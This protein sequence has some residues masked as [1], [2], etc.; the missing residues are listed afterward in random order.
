MPVYLTQFAYTAE[1]WSALVKHPED[2]SRVLGQLLEEVGGKLVCFYYAF[3]DYD[4][5]FI[6][7]AA[8][9]PASARRSRR[10]RWSPACASGW[11][12]RS[13]RCARTRYPPRAAR[14]RCCATTTRWTATPLTR[15][16]GVI[17]WPIRT[18]WRRSSRRRRAS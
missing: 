5:V 14:R 2:R 8:E 6:F 16:R 7:E 1:A 17:S 3:S 4:G 13:I 9:E 18:R 12:P 10:R 15:S 11:S